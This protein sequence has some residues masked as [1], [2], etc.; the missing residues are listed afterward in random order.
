[1]ATDAN[2]DRAATV[3]LRWLARRR[4]QALRPLWAGLCVTPLVGGAIAGGTEPWPPWLGYSALLLIPFAIVAL[5]IWTEERA[6]TRRVATIV[7]EGTRRR[8]VVQSV[9]SSVVGGDVIK[10]DRVAI[11]VR[12]DGG[13]TLDAAFEQFEHRGL[14]EVT[15]K[16]TAV[17]WTLDDR[18]VVGACGVLF[19]SS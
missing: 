14:P 18:S 16:A 2:H 15:E 3:A 4:R 19:E 12:L 5:V 13:E 1:M 8:G 10:R 6:R 17:V 9:G 7:S 11:A